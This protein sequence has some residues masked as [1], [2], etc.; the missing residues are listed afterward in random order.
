MTSKNQ[1]WKSEV[2]CCHDEVYN[3]G[4]ESGQVWD[5]KE[6]IGRPSRA[7]QKVVMIQTQRPGELDA[8]LT[9][10]GEATLLRE[11]SREMDEGF[12]KRWPKG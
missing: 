4:R 2:W 1:S 7:A 3:A 6:P 9:C 8:D 11:R 5:R 12:E 10:I